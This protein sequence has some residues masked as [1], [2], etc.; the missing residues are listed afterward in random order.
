MFLGIILSLIFIAGFFLI[1]KQFRTSRNLLYL[2]LAWFASWTIAYCLFISIGHTTLWLIVFPLLF[3]IAFIFSYY[4]EKCRLVNGLLFN[5]FLL[6]FA[7]YLLFLMIQT[8]T[9]LLRILIIILV[10]FFLLVL[11]LG[12][13]GL[14]VFLYWNAVIVLKRESHSLANLLTLL[15]AIGLTS[16]VILDLIQETDFLPD[17]LSITLSGVPLLFFYFFI[18]FCNFLS[19][20]LIYQLNQPKYQQD[21]IIVLGAGLLNGHIVSPLLARRIDKGIEFYRKQ[22]AATG[23]AAKLLMS[24]GQGPDEELPE[25]Q[26]MKQY[27]LAQ[28]I[29]EKD[30]LTETRSVNTL[31]NMKFSKELMDQ[32]SD[33]N[34]YHAIFTSN[35]YHI[36]RAGIYAQMAQL[37]ADGIGAKTAF[38]YL[39]NAILREYLAV[40]AM[41]KKRHIIVSGLIMFSSI[42]LGIIVAYFAK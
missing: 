32:L 38:Y 12:T 13:W 10:V 33:F 6:S 25:A 8:P 7:G 17:W 36:F 27:A 2:N 18:V 37:R 4:Q 3:L 26:A 14:L 29:P 15:L 41:K 16:L 22:L 23:K 5:L 9:L 34:E 40:L 24:G 31:Q 19:I 30:I 39:P 21:Y 20:S 42:A 1:R 28:G 35:N 11:S